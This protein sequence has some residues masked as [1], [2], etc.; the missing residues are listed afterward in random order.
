MRPEEPESWTG[1]RDASVEGPEC[2]QLNYT[3]YGGDRSGDED[4]LYLNVY[5]PE[6]PDSSSESK[7]VMVWIYGGAF[8]TGSSTESLYGSG[9]LIG[10]DVISV[11]LNY[12]LNVF[13]FLSTDDNVIPGNYGLWD[14]VQALQWVQENIAA[15][16]GDPSKVTIYGQSAGAMCVAALYLSPQ[17]EGLFHAA[18]SESGTLIL[19][20]QYQSDP[21]PYAQTLA[22]LVNCPTDNTSLMLPCLQ[23]LSQ[24]QIMDAFASFAYFPNTN[25]LYFTPVIDSKATV[26]LI[27]ENPLK[28]V[29]KGSYNKVPYMLGL[30][31]NEGGLMYQGELIAGVV[32]NK[33]FI[34]NNLSSLVS[35]FTMTS[36]DLLTELT[37]LI[38]DLY[39]SDIDLDNNTLIAEGVQAFISDAEFNIGNFITLTLLHK[40]RHAPSVYTYVFKYVGEFA[41]ERSTGMTTHTDELPYI[42]DMVMNNNG[43]LNSQD[44]VTSERILTLWTT[45]AKTGNP[46][47]GNSEVISTTW[48]RVTSYF[49]LPYFSIDTDLSMGENFRKKRMNYW[50][51]NIAPLYLSNVL[52]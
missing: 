23:A 6:I 11:T 40:G 19:P 8:Q 43:I 35:N 2:Y 28:T 16:G 7:A 22:G 9:K 3:V 47:P 20:G 38:Y 32:F 29:I 41:L 1:V 46:N 30:T 26:G 48:K 24:E 17:T 5:M 39:F 14:Q 33:D 45:F 18:I 52:N 42:F 21:L 34:E 31:Q 25:P 4:C 36:G 10:Y 49:N 27:P 51:K 44:N 12:R 15:F 37:P 50:I 13:G